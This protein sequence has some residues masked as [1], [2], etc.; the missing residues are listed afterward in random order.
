[1]PEAGQLEAEAR[2]MASSVSVVPTRAVEHADRYAN[3]ASSSCRCEMSRTVNG[4]VVWSWRSRWLAEG[5]SG[6]LKP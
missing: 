3:S 2:W 4:F 5:S 6:W 1:V